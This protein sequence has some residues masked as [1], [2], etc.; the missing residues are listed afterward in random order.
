MIGKL[1]L[2]RVRYGAADMAVLVPGTER[3]GARTVRYQAPSPR[4]AM[5]VLTVWS[6]LTS[7]YVSH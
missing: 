4:V 7:Q 1:G 3:T 5:D 2:G 6:T